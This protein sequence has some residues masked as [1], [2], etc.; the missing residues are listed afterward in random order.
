MDSTS[1]AAFLGSV[2]AINL[3]RKLKRD[4]LRLSITIKHKIKRTLKLQMRKIYKS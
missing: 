3:V 4:N 1:W 2:D